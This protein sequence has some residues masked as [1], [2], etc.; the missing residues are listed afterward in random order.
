MTQKL[1]SK[2]F[3]RMPVRAGHQEMTISPKRGALRLYGTG[4][5]HGG[6]G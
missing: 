2:Q 3:P 5:D 6:A 1:T 4:V